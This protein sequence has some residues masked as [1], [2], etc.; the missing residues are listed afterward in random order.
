MPQNMETVILNK[1]DIGFLE[2]TKVSNNITKNKNISTEEVF[3]AKET[4]Y[5]LSPD[6]NGG[7][8]FIDLA[9]SNA[10]HQTFYDGSKKIAELHVD[11]AGQL[12]FDTFTN[13]QI[14]L[15]VDISA[16]QCIINCKGPLYLHGRLEIKQ[17]L[18]IRSKSLYLA[19]AVSCDGGVSLKI[20]QGVV[21][22]ADI[23]AES[24]GV[25]AAYL[26]QEGSVET[27]GQY[28]VAVQ[29][30]QH[31]AK[32]K[33][34]VSS[35]R[36]VTEQSEISGE[37]GV[38]GQC[39]LTA[40]QLRFGDSENQTTIK[41]LG[42]NHIHAA[43]CVLKGDT[44]VTLNKQ[45]EEQ[46]SRC[47]FDNSL[48][49][50]K[51]AI[52]NAKNTRIKTEEL[53]NEGGFYSSACIIETNTI[54]Q[55]GIFDVYK[56]DVT[57]NK[58]FSQDSNQADTYLDQS[59]FSAPKS[60]IS[61][62]QMT[63]SHSTYTGKKFRM[64]DGDFILENQ[65]KMYMSQLIFGKS[66][67][68]TIE[69]SE[70]Y[71][72]KKFFLR[73]KAEVKRSHIETGSLQTFSHPINIEGSQLFVE[74]KLILGGGATIK[75]S[76]IQGEY[77]DLKGEFEIDKLRLRANILLFSSNKA[78]VKGS[79]I[80]TQILT[81]EGGSKHDNVQFDDCTFVTKMFTERNDIT[82]I[83]SKLIGIYSSEH[84]H[85][86]QGHLN[87]DGSRYV[88]R[89]Q[90]HVP[91]GGAINVGKLSVLQTGRLY[92]Q[93]KISVNQAFVFSDSLLQ[94]GAE[95]S[96]ANSHLKVK[97]GIFSIASQSNL[98]NN[99]VVTA[100]GFAGSQSDALRLT[101]RSVLRAREK[102]S[103]GKQSVMSGD[104]A[105]VQ[106]TQFV[107]LGKVELCKSMLSAQELL[108]YDKFNVSDKSRI[109]VAE[110]RPA[111]MLKKP[112]TLNRCLAYTLPARFIKLLCMV[113]SFPEKDP[114]FNT[115]SSKPRYKCFAEVEPIFSNCPPLACRLAFNFTLPA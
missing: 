113:I 110:M 1:N 47:I 26:L 48:Y 38:N 73:G 69:N 68:A 44:Q 10:S 3:S 5:K 25:E 22:S 83:D 76:Q 56:S 51:K 79:R 84:S 89:S 99:S 63:L 77:F 34:K 81:L 61:A 112:D 8:T 36:F 7:Y 41:L 14:N 87:L 97:G 32:A 94:R 70:L 111:L 40:N 60:M 100:G 90:V 27:A 102:I 6:K 52:L 72:T 53:H 9:F 16:D 24:L 80:K 12:I 74:W 43:D 62:G 30:F 17:A 106:A 78:I 4:S 85:E 108:I 58:K 18:A 46:S 39:F 67:H 15:F 105:A 31:T 95:F 104:D 107:A 101:G 50:D 65:S 28:D 29:A 55:N 11:N 82:L 35:L 64:R 33:T 71:N 2:K 19:D 109:N 115:K 21:F 49:V 98:S 37:F 114:Q 20:E 92:S 75:K 42:E 86:I 96:A 93:S 91:E 88:T 45:N 23:H 54:Q 59:L 66:A 57:V 13:K 103:I